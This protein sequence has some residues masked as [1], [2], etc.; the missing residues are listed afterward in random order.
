MTLQ[1]PFGWEGLSFLHTAKA[2]HAVGGGDE[3]TFDDDV[4]VVC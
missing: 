3:R 4:L 2:T 1:Q